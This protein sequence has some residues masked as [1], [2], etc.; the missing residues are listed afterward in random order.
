MTERGMTGIVD[1]GGGTRGIYGAGA[2]DFF[3]DR[4][5]TFDYLIGVSAGSANGVSFL[6]GQRGRNLRFYDRYAFRKEYMS[7]GNL[8]RRGSYVDLDYIYGT[9][10]NSGGEDPVDYEAFAANPAELVI[11]A[12][13]A[14]TGKPAYFYKKDIRKDHYD[15]LKASS[16]VPVVCRPWP[17]GGRCYYDGGISDPIPFRKAFDAGCDRVVVILTRPKDA[18]R[19]PGRDAA[20]ARIL[21]RRYPAA[22]RALAARSR[23]YNR[24]LARALALEK[25]G[26]VLILAPDSIG[27]LKTLSQDHGK[28][29]LLYRKGYNDA[30]KVC[31][32]LA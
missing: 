21:K 18:L 20:F 8:L 3:L 25:E 32:F 13:D 5:I 12:T 14:R 27:D 22:A 17:I 7:M 1:V 24:S 9:L 15:F 28:L 2:F 10:S 19:K 4:G 29:E 16:C 26:K 6:A 30:E 23:T 11:V 31:A